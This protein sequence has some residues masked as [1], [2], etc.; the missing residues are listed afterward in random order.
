MAA[1]I[2]CVK[3]TYPTQVDALVA[4]ASYRTC[5]TMRAYQC[6]WCSHWHLTKMPTT[7]IPQ[8]QQA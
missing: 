3:R 6:R 5:I 4:A 7:A 2:A 8:K 1:R